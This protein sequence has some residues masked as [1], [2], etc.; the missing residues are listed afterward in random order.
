MERPDKD[1]V[2]NN[3]LSLPENS[4]YQSPVLEEHLFIYLFIF[5]VLQGSCAC[6]ARA[7]RLKLCPSP[8]AFSLF[9]R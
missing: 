7:L 6:Y 2:C 1:I 9:F 5:V 3:T 8:F 4:E